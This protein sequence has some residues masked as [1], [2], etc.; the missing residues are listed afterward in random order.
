M[1]TIYFGHSRSFDYKKEWYEPIREL[2]L[3]T[4]IQVIFPH[5]TAGE[6]F[7][8]RGLFEKG[9]DLFVVEGSYPSTGLGIELGYARMLSVP[10]VCFSRKG[11]QISGSLKRLANQCIEYSDREDL[12]VKLGKLLES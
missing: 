4:E 12:K 8:T 11:V 2:N 5:E 10:I 9:C 3:P 7:D 1:K 6:D